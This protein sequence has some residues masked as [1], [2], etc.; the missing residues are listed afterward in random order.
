MKETYYFSHDYNVRT[1]EKIKSLIRKHGMEGYGVYWS[2]VEDLYNNAN[3]LLLDYDGIAYD[4]RVN[5]IIVESI[6]N[7]FKLF[8]AND[9]TFSSISIQKRLDMRDEKSNKAR[10][11]VAKRWEK[12]TNVLRDEYD[13]NTIKESKVK[14]SKVNDIDIDSSK[15][16]SV[17]N[18]IL[19]KQAR[20]VPV[21]AKTQL[22]QRLKEGYT[23]DDIVNAIRNASKD[24]HHIDSNYKYLTLEFITRSDKL[25]RFVTMADFKIKTQIL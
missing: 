13:S 14:E 17:F 11:S 9:Q 22:K 25:E 8:E 10:A 3:V 12:Y 20:V 1:D 6:I 5:S 16:L 23:K 24:P 7:D 21:K 15:L 18:S 4:L 2:I 19:G